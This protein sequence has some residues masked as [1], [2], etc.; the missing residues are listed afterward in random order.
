M[1]KGFTY[2]KG[3]CKYLV[4]MFLIS[5][6]LNLSGRKIS[7]SLNITTNRVP[8][9]QPFYT[10]LVFPSLIKIFLALPHDYLETHMD[11]KMF[12]KAYNLG[13]Y[14]VAF[15]LVKASWSLQN[16]AYLFYEGHLRQKK[17]LNLVKYAPKVNISMKSL[18]NDF[19][20]ILFPKQI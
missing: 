1:C 19:P 3:L 4:L 12:W 18:F 6:A 17:A 8:L 16:S 20:S 15:E 7:L 2:C 10:L 14:S 13:W 5:W 9:N 11:V